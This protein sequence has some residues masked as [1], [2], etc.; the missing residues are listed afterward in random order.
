[1][2]EDDVEAMMLNRKDTGVDTVDMTILV[3]A[4]TCMLTATNLNDLE[5]YSVKAQTII[6][7][8]HRLKR[9]EIIAYSQKPS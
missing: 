4:L 1:M 2:T 7:V 5:N 9:N 6:S 8:I 3:L